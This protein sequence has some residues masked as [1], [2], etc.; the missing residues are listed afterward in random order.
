MKAILVIDMPE[1]CVDC[2][3]HQ[4][5]DIENYENDE[6]RC[7]RN[8]SKTFDADDDKPSWC[9]LK[10]MPK[11][12]EYRADTK[13][14]NMDKYSTGYADGWNDCLKEILD[15]SGSCD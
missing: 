4:W 8:R 1:K 7:L 11:R 2:D 9:P 5:V 13:Y 15:E 10:P 14:E 6:I 12:N 3:L